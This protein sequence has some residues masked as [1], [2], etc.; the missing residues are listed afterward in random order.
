MEE[1][2]GENQKVF[3]IHLFCISQTL[4]SEILLPAIMS[5]RHTEVRLLYP[6]FLKKGDIKGGCV[7]IGNFT[8]PLPPSSKGDFMHP[9][10]RLNKMKI[11]IQSSY[12]SD[13]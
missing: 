4:M 5:L 10:T 9:K 12:Y 13:F 3:L 1:I 2:G 6:L 8:T 11:P 7:F